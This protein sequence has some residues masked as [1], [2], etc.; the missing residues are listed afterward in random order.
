MNLNII[1]LIRTVVKTVYVNF[2]YFPVKDAIKLPI[3]IAGDVELGKLGSKGCLTLGL[4]KTGAVR[5]GF[6]GSFNLG[7]GGVFP[8]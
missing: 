2:H 3:W 4:K 7:T 1:Y 8:H 6:G 5:F